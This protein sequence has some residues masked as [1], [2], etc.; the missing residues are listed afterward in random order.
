MALDRFGGMI[1]MILNRFMVNFLFY[2]LNF[3][4]K[5]ESGEFLKICPIVLDIF[6]QTDGRMEENIFVFPEK[7][8]ITPKFSP[9]HIFRCTLNTKNMKNPKNMENM[10]NLGNNMGNKY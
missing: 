6:K 10:G 1:Y 9:N 5:V 3:N 4:S 8:H 2:E 7:F